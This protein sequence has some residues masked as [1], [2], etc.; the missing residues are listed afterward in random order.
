MDISLSSRLDLVPTEIRQDKKHYIVEDK[1]SGE[2][3]EMPEIC[4]DAINLIHT[5]MQLGDIERGLKEKYPDEDVDVVDFAKQLLEM[6]LIT[7]ID[8]VKVEIQEMKK[9]S[10][11]FMWISPK[12]GKFFFNKAAYFVYGALFLINVLFFIWKPSLFPHYKDLFIFN[13]MALNIPAW[14]ILSFCLVLIHEYGHVLALRAHNLPT[15]LEIGHRLFIVVFET[16]MSSVW[17]LPSKDRNVLYLA[18]L[19]FDTVILFFA[20]SSQLIFANGSGIFLNI[21]NVVV[22]T[23]F[24]R[25]VYQL[26]VYMKTDLYYVFE[27]VSGCYNLM[28]NAQQ[29]IRKWLPFRVAASQNEVVFEEEKKTVFFYSIFYFA[30]VFL[31]ISLFVFYYIPQLMFALKKSLPGFLEGP[32]SLPFWDAV[33][34]VL[35][36]LIG[37]MLLLYSW[38]KKYLQ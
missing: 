1:A 29:M 37:L 9:E 7:E 33:L 12:L 28:E 20:L 13:L 19:C 38:R 11:G 4:I 32:D 35:Q 14:L 27:N 36:I 23:T 2:F 26:G 5:G 15:K 22:L 16:D 6:Q 10:L 8:G 18:G 30:G 17:Q 25:M 3:Y 24:I 31:T 34:F 21:M